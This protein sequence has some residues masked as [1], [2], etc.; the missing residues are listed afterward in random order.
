MQNLNNEIKIII[1]SWGAY[2]ACNSKAYGS[3]WLNLEN[4]SSVE[5]IEE[6][7]KKQGFNLEGEDEELF[8]QDIEGLEVPNCDYKNPFN[9]IKFIYDHDILDNYNYKLFNALCEA[10]SFDEAVNKFENG[11]ADDII[12]YQDMT[13]YE[14]AVEIMDEDLACCGVPDWV[15][16]YIDYAQFERD[17]AFDNYFE[18]SEGVLLID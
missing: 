14:V 1:G 2:N 11:K 10:L 18:T 6:E 17:L 12:F 4:F 3:S 13:L 9:L 16:R 5:E 7:L 8:I 15:C